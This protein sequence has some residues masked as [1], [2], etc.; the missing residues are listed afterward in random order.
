M[1]KVSLI[2]DLFQIQSNVLRF[3]NYALFFQTPYL[4]IIMAFYWIIPIATIYPPG[5]L[6]LRLQ[7]ARLDTG[8]NVSTF[9]RDTK[10]HPELLWNGLGLN[11]SQLSYKETDK[12]KEECEVQIRY[13]ILG[14]QPDWIFWR[15]KQEAD[16][17]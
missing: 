12:L 11:C 15:L 17:V 7:S 6:V 2:E 8:F 14:T 3:V 9:D 1:L 10:E 16:T 4:V 5:A 13:V